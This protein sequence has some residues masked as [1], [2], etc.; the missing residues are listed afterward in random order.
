MCAVELETL[1][2]ERQ[3]DSVR[4]D[5]AVVDSD[6]LGALV[7]AHRRD[8]GH[9]I[10]SV[11]SAH[12]LVLEAVCA[13]AAGHGE[14]VLI[15]ATSNQVNQ[16]GGYTGLRPR[17]FRDQVLQIA[18]RHDL[19]PD[20]IVLGG[21]HLGPNPWRS[22]PAHDAMARAEELVVAFAEAGYTKIH[23]D[24]SMPCADDPAPLTDA[25]VS[26][27]AARLL[28]RAERAAPDPDAVSYVI[29]TEV[30][31]PGGAMEAIA[32]LQP[33]TPAAARATLAAHRAAFDAAGVGDV[34]GRVR[35][36]VVQPGVE[37]DEWRVVDYEPAQ[38]RS[39]RGV[40]GHEPGMVFE[41]HSTDYQTAAALAALVHDHWAVLKVGP[42]LTFALREALFALE[43]IEREL[44]PPEERSDLQAILEARM[45][46]EPA[47]WEG[48]Y[49]HEGD[50]R[51]AR[52][53]SYSDRARYYWPDAEVH[54]AQERLFANL[55]AV[56]LPLPLLSQALPAQYARVRAGDLTPE[57]RALVIDQ[58]AD[59]LRAYRWACT[60]RRAAA[61]AT[62][63]DA[64][65]ADRA[66]HGEPTPESRS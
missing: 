36:L 7:A 51:L 55:H 62:A 8:R 43:A 64:A 20:R 45:L 28:A 60:R 21:D 24:C 46:A 18:S 2:F 49:G 40:L 35:A 27:R 66:K 10:T 9:G 38:T 25:I 50:A 34:W 3:T 65:T 4:S 14:A 53:F 58:I 37:F 32:A 57:P 15:E 11:C 17:D 63:A 13:D 29:G 22:R 41:A 5:A 12:P 52:R 54:A 59:V 44:C 42:G 1:T 61:V 16:D 33:T 30:P 6:A 47:W 19:R 26:D 23:L 48:H 39:L 31:E 56:S